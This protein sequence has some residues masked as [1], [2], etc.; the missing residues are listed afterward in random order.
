MPHAVGSAALV[1]PTSVIEPEFHGRPPSN[2]VT[3]P[4]ELYRL[5]RKS[6][7]CKNTEARMLHWTVT[8]WEAAERQRCSAESTGCKC[9]DEGQVLVLPEP[10][11]NNSGKREVKV[12]SRQ[13]DTKLR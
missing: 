11:A 4:T 5:Q 7:F 2:V 6:H 10:E 1:Y 9:Q 13:S 3:I 8:V 12:T